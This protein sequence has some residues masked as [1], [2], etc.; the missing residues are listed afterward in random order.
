MIIY[1]IIGLYVYLLI[2]HYF[3]SFLKGIIPDEME[4]SEAGYPLGRPYYIGMSLFWPILVVI[5]IIYFIFN[6][7]KLFKK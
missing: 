2:A 6:P 5:C 3:Y 7:H 4:Y 1:I